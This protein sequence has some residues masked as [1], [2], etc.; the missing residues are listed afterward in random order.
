MAECPKEIARLVERFERNIDSYRAPGYKEAQV[1]KEFIDPLFEALGW[2]MANKAG[3]AE[4][5]KDVVHEATVKISGGTKA[6]DYC[7][8]IGGVPKFFLEAKR[9]SPSNSKFTRSSSENSNHPDKWAF[10][11][12]SLG[13]D[14]DDPDD[15][16]VVRGKKMR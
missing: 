11:I 5:Y 3:K 9:P 12:W 1:R 16:I 15:D 10:V 4:A 13:R 8:R 14:K 7:F 2:D 6:P